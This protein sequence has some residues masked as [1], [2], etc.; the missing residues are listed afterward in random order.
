[1]ERA[2]VGAAERDSHTKCVRPSMQ[3]CATELKGLRGSI[4][5]IIAVR[6]CNKLY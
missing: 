3:G 6:L 5:S 1:M 2:G 4:N